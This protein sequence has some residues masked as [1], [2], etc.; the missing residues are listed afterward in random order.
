MA[1]NFPA[2]DSLGV[3][4]LLTSMVALGPIST[5]LYLPTLPLLVTTFASDAATVQLTLSVFLIGFALAQLLY[6]PLSD[7]FGRRP[8]VLTGVTLYLLGS[9]AC[10]LAADIQM[11]IL[12]RLVQA[13]GA[14]C[15]PVLGRAI[16]RDVY[17][18]ERAAKVL[19]YMA[20][21]MA[22]APAVGP[23]LG[24][25][26]AE[27]WG[28]RSCFIALIGFGG[29]VWIGIFFALAE[30]NRQHDP[31]AL[32]PEQWLANHR[33][34]FAHRPYMGYVLCSA[35]AYGGIFSFIS[36]SSFVLMDTVGLS[37]VAYGFC[38]T[39]VVVGYMAGSFS[40]G[41]LSIRLGVDRMIRLGALAA[42]AGGSIALALALLGV[43]T[44]WAIV[45]PL[46]LFFIG[47]AFILPN[48]MAGAVGPFPHMAGL[49]SAFLGFVQMS[50]AALVG[51]AVGHGQDGTARAMMLAVFLVSLGV[52]LAQRYG[53]SGTYTT[54]DGT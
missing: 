39:T 28:W 29:L 5:D 7:R 34:L 4:V 15:G 36:G 32:V 20:M 31:H 12:A 53:R 52:W 37:P 9:L 8:M 22:I 43:I 24:G 19:A 17:G 6:G 38:F 47:A 35:C 30:T 49:A 48:A 27:A 40:A 16:V 50:S 42:I 21:A 44:V 46:V 33:R 11:L 26:L 25:L 1:R 14:C 2:A 54:P 13:V 51:L 10:A 3:A 41:R 45:G 23:V 18:R